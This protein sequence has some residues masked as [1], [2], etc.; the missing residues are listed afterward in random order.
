MKRKITLCL[1]VVMAF[2]LNLYA[3]KAMTFDEAAKQGVPYQDL[4]KL[5]KSAVHADVNLAVFKT[6]QEQEKLIQAYALFMQNLGAYLKANN[7]NWGKQTKCFNRTYFAK[8]GTVDYFLYQFSPDQI[9]VEKEKEFAGLLTLFIKDHK[10]S[11]T[12][13]EPFAQCSPIKYE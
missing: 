5:Y 9:T 13:N 1:L 2:T 4:D 6:P 7:F 10:F 12:A 3:Q 8:N 11:L